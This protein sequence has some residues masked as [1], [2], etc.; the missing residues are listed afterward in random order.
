[1]EK[2][3]LSSHRRLLSLA[4]PLLVGVGAHR[5]CAA[6]LPSAPD[7]QPPAQTAP[8]A[9]ASITGTITDKDGASIAAARVT[10]TRDNQPPASV[11]TAGDGTF[12]FP[13]LG[14]GPFQLSIVAAG[15]SPQQTSGVLQPD[16]QLELPAFALASASTTNIDVQADQTKIADAQVNREEKQRVLGAIPNFYVV[17]DQ[18]PVPLDPKQKSKLA[19]RTL[20]DP[21]NLILNGVTAGVQQATDTYAWQQGADGYAKRY[22]AAFGT[23]LTS[24][25]LTSAVLPIVFHQDP[26]YYYKGTGSVRSRA[27]YAIANAVMCKGDNGHWQVNYSGILGGLAASGISNVY[28]PAANRAGAGLTFEGAAIG[29][30]LAAVANL[31]EEFVVRKI[32]PR[33]P[34]II[35][36][37]P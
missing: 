15:F 26:R 2:L 5:S 25:L 1:M 21:V 29:T 24:D 23:F 18:N 22:A 28:Y 37:N 16:Q 9:A 35:P 27:G 4:L 8:A 6:E 33:I 14:P 20:I 36:P 13:S 19:L 32:T 17:Y 12:T 3:R 34:P 10:L 31:F 30:G 7:P 11:T